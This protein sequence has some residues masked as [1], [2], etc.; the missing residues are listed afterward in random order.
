MP[1]ILIPVRFGGTTHRCPNCGFRIRGSA[2][3]PPT[4][5]G[6][7]CR[8]CGAPFRLRRALFIEG[9]QRCFFWLAILPA[10]AALFCGFSSTPRLFGRDIE[11]LAGVSLVGSLLICFLA[12]TVV[13]A[14][15]GYVTF[16]W[17][18]SR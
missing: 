16:A 1:F 12:S 6:T 10:W 7:T 11:T 4:R 5:L 17:L 18:E 13:R 2:F 9:W 8:M 15:V 14:V 3:P